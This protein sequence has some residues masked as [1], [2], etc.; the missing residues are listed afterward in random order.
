MPLAWRH[1]CI[2]ARALRSA[3]GLSILNAQHPG[4]SHHPAPSI[5]MKFVPAPSPLNRLL[6][7]LRRRSL[8]TAV[9]RC[10]E[11]VGV[12]RGNRRKTPARSRPA[13]ERVRWGSVWYLSPS[14]ERPRPVRRANVRYKL[15]VN[16]A[17]IGGPNHRKTPLLTGRCQPVWID[18]TVWPCS[19]ILHT[20]AIWEEGACFKNPVSRLRR[21]RRVI[22]CSF[23]C[24]EH[25]ASLAATGRD[26][27]SVSLTRCRTLTRISWIR[28]CY[29]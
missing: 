27:A 11:A 26:G 4:A 23:G 18:R 17:L 24:D 8:P 15:H 9:R 5:L 7:P 25:L 12:P 28:A 10:S 29:C 19:A 20:A 13:S 3:V 21:F 22:T 16:A 2:C 6:P 14:L 1:I